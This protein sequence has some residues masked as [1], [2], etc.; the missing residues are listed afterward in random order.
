M[1]SIICRN[2]ETLPNT[3]KHSSVAQVRQCQGAP[4][5]WKPAP[6]PEAPVRDPRNTYLNPKG[7]SAQL[8]AFADSTVRPETTTGAPM[9]AYKANPPS[10]V[11]VDPEI[12][13]KVPAGRYAVPG[14]DG[15]IKFYRVDKPTEGT[16]AGRTFVKV[17]A[18]DDWLPVRYAT[19][20]QGILRKIGEDVRAASIRYGLELGQCG[21]CG[22]TLTNPES[23]AKG[24]GPVCEGRL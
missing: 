11:R 18:G 4:R 12:E 13:A 14:D 6:K 16:W 5:D 1:A 19:A 8:A 7:I 2:G 10:Q 17:R 24:I 22:R 23:I 3:H 9:A 15:V 20:R 21:V